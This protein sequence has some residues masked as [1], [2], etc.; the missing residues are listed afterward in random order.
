MKSYLSIVII[1]N[2]VHFY[3]EIERVGVKMP[4]RCKNYKNNL[5]QSLKKAMSAD[6]ISTAEYLSL[7]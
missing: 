7:N 4:M 6:S 5:A 2:N 3:N 1:N